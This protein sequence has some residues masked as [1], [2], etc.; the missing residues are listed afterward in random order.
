MN[1]NETH[2]KI[3]HLIGSRYVSSVRAYIAELTGYPRVVGPNVTT[4]FEANARDRIFIVV[5]EAGIIE[6]F[7]FG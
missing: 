2:L 5:N 4:T 6:S 7:R 1:R 3:Q